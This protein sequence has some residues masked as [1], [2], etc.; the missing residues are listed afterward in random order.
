MFL[1]D[2]CLSFYNLGAPGRGVVNGGWRRG[3]LRL[4]VEMTRAEWRISDLGTEVNIFV[5]EIGRDPK[6]SGHLWHRCFHVTW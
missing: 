4:L 3:W 6:I 2:I 5:G 1:G